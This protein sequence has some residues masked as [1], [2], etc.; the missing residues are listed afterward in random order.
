MAKALN[1][2]VATMMSVS[3]VAGTAGGAILQSPSAGVALSGIAAVVVSAAVLML[4]RMTL[5]HGQ[6]TGCYPRWDS[7]GFEEVQP[8]PDYGPDAVIVLSGEDDELT[9]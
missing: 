2:A 1:G 3:A 7:F 4:W 9:A 8:Q 5:R 6:K